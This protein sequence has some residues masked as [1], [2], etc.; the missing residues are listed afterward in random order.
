VL[1]KR[2][3][4]IPLD[5]DDLAE[6]GIGID[7]IIQDLK[8]VDWRNNPDVKKDME[9]QVEEYLLEKSASTGINLTFDEIDLILEQALQIAHSHRDK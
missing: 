9:N 6:I 1:G 4:G 3:N 2:E 8:I 7:Q 5:D